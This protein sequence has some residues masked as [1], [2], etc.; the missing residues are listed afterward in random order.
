MRNHVRTQKERIHLENLRT[1]VLAVPRTIRPNSSLAAPM[2]RHAVR[3]SP[4]RR[5]RHRATVSAVAKIRK[6]KIIAIQQRRR[7]AIM[8]RKV[9]NTHRTITIRPG[10][11]PNHPDNLYSMRSVHDGSQSVRT[12]EIIHTLHSYL[13]SHFTYFRNL[14]FSTCR[15]CWRCMPLN[16][17]ITLDFTY[18]VQ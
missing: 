1:Q 9:H 17:E 4:T 14:P 12:K 7:V 18:N 8:N 16:Q 13:I 15:N 3:K 11:V 10:K 2:I 5:H 6:A